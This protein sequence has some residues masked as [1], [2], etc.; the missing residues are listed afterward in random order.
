MKILYVIPLSGGG[1]SGGRAYTLAILSSLNSIFGADNIDLV[2]TDTNPDTFANKVVFRT[3]DATTNFERLKNIVCGDIAKRS[4][5]D[6][7]TIIRLVTENRYELV[8]LGDSVAGRLT[9]RIKKAAP[10]TTTMTIYNDIVADQVRMNFK[11]NFSLLKIPAW[12]AD[13]HLEKLDARYTDIPVVLHKRDADLLKKYWKRETTNYLPIALED[14]FVAD[15]AGSCESPMLKLLFVGNYHWPPNQQAISW[16]CQEVMPFLHDGII[17]LIVGQGT[18]KAVNDHHI[19]ALSNVRVLG[20][21]ADLSAVYASADVVVEP[22]VAGSGM[23]VK[24]AEA[25]M[26]GKYILGTPEALV[27]YEGLA[28]NEC[29][30]A[31]E[32][33][34]RLNSLLENRPPKFIE[35]YRNYYEEEFSLSAMKKHLELILGRFLTKPVPQSTLSNS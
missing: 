7:D 35:K 33:V 25:L 6:V 24:T 28:E 19:G 5:K 14:T 21:V 31:N 22:I 2:L 34:E 11:N 16:F 1:L 15:S 29:L 26:H 10:E 12:L 30:D 13:I 3:K 4:K 17:F 8:V 27:G 32:F 23:K 20:T 18:E 9:K